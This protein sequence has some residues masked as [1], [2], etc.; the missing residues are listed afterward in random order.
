MIRI[1]L[2]FFFF[3]GYFISGADWPQASGPNGDFV[4][5]TSHPLRVFS[6]AKNEKVRWRTKLPSTGQG[7]PVVSGGRIFVTS[8]ER[9]KEDT[10]TGSTIV[11]LCFDAS[12]GKELW[13]RK[14]PGTRT[15]DLSSLFSDNTAA[16]PVTDGK[17]VVFCNVGGTVKCFNY[18]GDE[19]WSHTW[20]PFG[21]HHARAHEPI[22]HEGKVILMHAPL[23]D[24]PVSATTKEGSK[25]LG[26]GR[27]YWTFLRAYDLETGKLIWQA[28][29]GT[30]V[31]STSIL[32]RLP[33]GRQAILTGRGGGHQPPEEPYGLSLLD[34][35]NGKSIWDR[36]IKGYAAAQNACWAKKA[37]HFFVD[38]EH[39]SIALE[40]GKTFKRVSLIEGVTVTRRKGSGY[41][42][43]K[44]QKL[45]KAKKPITYFTNLIVGDYHYF[46]TFDGFFIG[47]INLKTDRV[48]YLQVPVQ[49][50]RTLESEDQVLWDKSIANDMRNADGFKATQ[51]KRN[52]GNG[53]GHVSYAPP[54]VAGNLIYFPTMVGMVYILKWNALELNE[55]ALVSVS[56]LGI[57]GETW[58]LSGLAY[59]D[60]FLYART[61]K[62]LICLGG[63]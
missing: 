41:I 31:H 15:T 23:Y 40:T 54:I 46:R 45:N 20:T 18:Q 55:T 27:E 14:I 21:R 12:T 59:A 61:M 49:V 44:D 57:A 32:G 63:D 36:A 10:Q 9:I 2:I 48:E 28:E 39:C 33:D 50:I 17:R 19:L 47:R 34:A 43:L 8:H 4:V 53:W 42:T 62:E 37:A 52:A 30:S 1:P 35:V 6:V 60:C 26:R 13:R 38:E 51:D 24:L 16:S 29:E 56:D 3:V 25:G 58:S 7:T 11:G 22:I 5:S